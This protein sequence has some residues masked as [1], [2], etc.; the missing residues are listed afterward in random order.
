VSVYEGFFLK[1]VIGLNKEKVLI[2]N[3]KRSLQMP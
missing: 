2:S 3:G 1:A